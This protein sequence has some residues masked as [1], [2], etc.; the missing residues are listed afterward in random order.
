MNAFVL[1]RP[2]MRLMDRLR[3]VHKLILDPD[4]DSFYVMD[5]LT[6]KVPALLDAMGTRERG[7]NGDKIADAENKSAIAVNLS[8]MGDGLATSFTHTSDTRLRGDLA[9]ALAQV[10]KTKGRAAAAA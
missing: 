6:T 2:S 5:S 1:L 10:Q 4:L 3:L 7:F 8:G 9:P